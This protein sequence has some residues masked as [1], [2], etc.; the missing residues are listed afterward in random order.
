MSRDDYFKRILNAFASDLGRPVTQEELDRLYSQAVAEGLVNEDE[1]ERSFE[2]FLGRTI[3]STSDSGE[4]TLVPQE[5]TTVGALVLAY[6]KKRGLTEKQLARELAVRREVIIL[7]E[8]C[9]EP[10]DT[11]RLPALARTVA[12]EVPALKPADA[13]RLLQR[14]RVIFGLQAASGPSLRAARRRPGK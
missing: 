3:E 2:K 9:E 4:I 12:A 7:V 6:R 8:A 1:L 14:I 5:P 10:Y 13:Q 11:E